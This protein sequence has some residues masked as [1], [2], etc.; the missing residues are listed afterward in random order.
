LTIKSLA[1]QKNEGISSV[2]I[3]ET[4]IG[5]WHFCCSMMFREEQGAV[6][7]MIEQ[8]SPQTSSP[9]TSINTQPEFKAGFFEIRVDEKLENPGRI[10]NH[11][12]ETALLIANADLLYR[13]EE[14][15]LAI[16]LIRQALYLN[17]NHPEA[18]KRLAGW[19]NEAAE[20]PLK[21]RALE[22]LSKEDMRFDTVAQLAHCYYNAGEDQLAKDTYIDAL[23]LLT[24]ESSELFEVYKNLGNIALHEKDYEAAEELYNKAFT[25]RSN[26]D[27][28]AVNLGTLSL[29]QNE[30]EEA[31]VRFR[32]ALKFNPKNDKAWVGLAMVHN[33]KG[34]FALAKGNL[35]NALDANPKNRTAVHLFAN[36]SLRDQDLNPA[37][38][39]LEVYLS[40]HDCDKEMSLVLIHLFCLRNKLTEALLEVERVLLWEPTD[41]KLQ[42]VEKEIRNARGF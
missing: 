5:G 34:D 35:E 17:S 7:L 1:S 12:N 40:H 38:E 10:A 20:L 39:A 6:Q 3:E 14:K 41:A 31:A 2:R 29:Q 13:H 27:T 42:Q 19:L 18:L 8:L 37:M 4:E 26:S 25:L 33:Q 24:D 23:K 15:S 21:T 28:L 32:T 30:M 11:R 16:S 22:A 36:W 9:S